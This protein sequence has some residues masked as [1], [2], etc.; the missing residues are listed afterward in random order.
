MVSRWCP[1]WCFDW[2]P[3]GVPVVSLWCPDG[4]LPAPQGVRPA[5]RCQALRTGGRGNWPNIT[6]TKRTP[7]WA[8][9]I[10]LH[11]LSPAS[12]LC[13]HISITHCGQHRHH[14]SSPT[15]ERITSTVT[16]TI[17]AVV[18]SSPQPPFHPKGGCIGN[19][20]RI[21]SKYIK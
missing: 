4:A 1:R 8:S 5:S 18:I 9:W 21:Y 2:C 16:I 12:P 10:S 14:A 19:M 20:Y 7:R 3:D 15:R 13:S 11:A 17:I 6:N